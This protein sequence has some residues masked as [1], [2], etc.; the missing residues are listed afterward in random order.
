MKIIEKPNRNKRIAH[1]FWNRRWKGF[2]SI[3]INNGTFRRYFRTSELYNLAREMLSKSTFS[4]PLDMR[5]WLARQPT[6]FENE[7]TVPMGEA[8]KLSNGL[9]VSPFQDNNFID[10]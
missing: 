1:G 6:G 8:V 9:F 2:A 7:T 4:S 10:S 5:N 3:T